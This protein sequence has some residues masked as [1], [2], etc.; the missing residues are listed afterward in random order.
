MGIYCIADGYQ[1]RLEPEPW[2]DKDLTEEWQRE[3]YLIAASVAAAVGAKRVTDIGCGSGFKLITYLG[4]LDTVGVDTPDTVMWLKQ[5]YPDRCWHVNWDEAA[6]EGGADLVICADVIEH[7]P[8]PNMLMGLIKACAKRHAPILIS[9]PDRD[10]FGYSRESGLRMGPPVNRSHA[11][12][13]TFD[14]FHAYLSTHYEIVGHMITNR[15]QTTQLAI[16]RQ[17]FF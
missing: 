7:F 14:E 15:A 2:D 4:H 3:V 12:E 9:T 5:R 10:L 11:R 1:H 6:R 8:D 16:C 13:W 17:K